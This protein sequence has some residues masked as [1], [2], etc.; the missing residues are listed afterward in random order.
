M[1][2]PSYPAH[3]RDLARRA[4]K[5]E[6]RSQRQACR[7]FEINRSTFRYEAK[8]P[9][10]YRLAVQLAIV[11]LRHEY[12]EWGTDKIRRSVRKENHRVRLIRRQEGRLGQ[13]TGRR[14]QKAFYPGH[15]WNWEFI[16]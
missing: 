11:R 4:K 7:F 14:P 3:R 10:P 13:S 12:P 15:V 9:S 8:I 1:N 2:K 5:E 6:G 16:H